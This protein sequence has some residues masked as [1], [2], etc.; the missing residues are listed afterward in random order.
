MSLLQLVRTEENVAW[1]QR[2]RGA[3]VNRREKQHRSR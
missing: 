2:G 3:R 1:R